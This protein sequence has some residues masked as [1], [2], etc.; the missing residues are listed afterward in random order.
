MKD[1]ISTTWSGKELLN[2]TGREA[3]L[4]ASNAFMLEARGGNGDSPG[5][6]FGLERVLPTMFPGRVKVKR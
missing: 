6:Q 4:A 3:A 2:G 5:W 1:N